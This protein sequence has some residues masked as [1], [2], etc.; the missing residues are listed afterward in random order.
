MVGE[1]AIPARYFLPFGPYGASASLKTLIL[2]LHSEQ[3]ECKLHCE[4]FGIKKSKWNNEWFEPVE[5]SID[6]LDAIPYFNFSPVAYRGGAADQNRYPLY[7]FNADASE[8][9]QYWFKN[10]PNESKL[11]Y[12][13]KLF[14]G[15]NATYN[16]YGGIFGPLYSTSQD[17]W[18]FCANYTE[19]SE[20]LQTDLISQI[21][22]A[23]LFKALW[24]Q[25]NVINIELSGT[26][27][28]N[29]DINYTNAGISWP[30]A[31]QRGL[32]YGNGLDEAAS[33]N[34]L[35]SYLMELMF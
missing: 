29:Y 33:D 27:V 20:F 14:H 19:S 13:A 22:V 15:Y 28:S 34:V 1:T 17:D 24:Q 30:L 32:K 4:K 23:M 7:P 2:A 12:L 26:D 35:I 21:E 6:D 25:T 3:G 9:N 31:T 11:N 5:K 16:K 8:S 18:A 10:D